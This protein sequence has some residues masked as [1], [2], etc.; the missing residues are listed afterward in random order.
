M[1]ILGKDVSS[2]HFK[3]KSKLT[4]EMYTWQALSY[5]ESSKNELISRIEGIDDFKHRN[6]LLLYGYISHD[7][8]RLLYLI[9]EFCQNGNLQDAVKRCVDRQEYFSEE[10]LW[11]TFYQVA[12]ALKAAETFDHATISTSSLL[13]DSNYNVK[14]CLISNCGKGEPDCFSLFCNVLYQLC[15]ASSE[16]NEPLK[17]FPTYYSHSLKELIRFLFEQ[18]SLTLK[19]AIDT[20][21][22][23]P[24]SLLSSNCNAITSNKVFIK[25]HQD[26]TCTQNA[27]NESIESSTARLEALKIR[28]CAVKSREQRLC[29]KEHEL[30]KREKKVTLMERTVKEKMS[31]AELYLKRSKSTGKSKSSYENLDTSFSADCGDSIIVPTAA[32][33]GKTFMRTMSERRVHFKGHSPLKKMYNTNV[34]SGR[35]ATQAQRAPMQDIKC[36]GGSS[37]TGPHTECFSE[38][39]SDDYWTKGTV[40]RRS[41]L[42]S[43]FGS[44][45]NKT[46]PKDGNDNRNAMQQ[47]RP[48]SWTNESKQHA[49]DLLRILNAENKENVDVPVKHT[50]L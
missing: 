14:L 17:H 22:H 20:I 38:A 41:Q 50:Y 4:N 3:V 36:G 1:G 45:K 11:R 47:C 35:I 44:S 25:K 13:L 10:F 18:K 46:N 28:E 40:K 5:A 32:K 24:N 31:R 12:S 23:H 8:S 15:L 43:I 30:R 49:F 48:I 6:L 21:L 2:T 16:S 42:F 39:S 34:G 7:K 26:Q 33:P 37:A 19:T 29:E 9:T 27:L